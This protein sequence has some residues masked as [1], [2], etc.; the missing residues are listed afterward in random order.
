MHARPVWSGFMSFGL[1]TVPVRAYTASNES[2]S[3][4][5]FNQLHRECNSRIQYKKVC[6]IHG[7]IRSD[8]IVSGYEFAD[9]QYVTFDPA[10]LEK[11]RSAKDKTIA[12]SAFVPPDAVDPVYHAGGTYYLAPDGA[13][14]QKPY[15]LIQ[16]V[17][18][19]R[20]STPSPRWCCASAS[21]WC[22]FGRWAESSP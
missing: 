6:P 13:V 3:G 17:M 11:L 15:T 7:E 5:R 12:I 16:R 2:E 20:G 8:E 1:V 19:R 21:R 10:D 9:G 14:A 18:E 4:V 22:C